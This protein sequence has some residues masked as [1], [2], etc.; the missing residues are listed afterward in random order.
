MKKM[1]NIRNGIIIILCLTIIFMAIG[2]IIISLKLESFK[3]NTQK[4]NVV[5]DKIIKDSSTKGGNT[6]PLGNVEII[7]NGKILNMDFTL[8]NPHDEISYIIKIKNESSTNA[9][10]VDLL[11][12]PDYKDI[13]YNYLI[14]PVS[15]TYNDI[16]GRELKPNEELDLKITVYYNPSTKSGKK[17]FNDKMGLITESV[18]A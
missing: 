3:N 11:Q 12:S 1:L 10:I 2:F 7:A 6:E 14:D 16:V 4:Y 5:F 15:I 9:L 13:N 17:T 18:E 8:N